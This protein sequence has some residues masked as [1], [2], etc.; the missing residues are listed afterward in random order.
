MREYYIFGAH[1]RGWTLYEYLKLVKPQDKIL[2]FL[3]DNDEDNPKEIEGV[4]VK[5]IPDSGG[6]NADP[7]ATNIFDLNVAAVIYI[8]TRGVFHYKIEMHLRSLGFTDIILVT[9]ELDADLRNRFMKNEFAKRDKHFI[10][11]ERSLPD[12]ERNDD[13]DMIGRVSDI[14]L[15]IAKTAQD[16][17]LE[18]NVS[19]QD[20]EKIIQVGCDLTDIV[21][22]DA[23]EFDNKGDNISFRNSQFCELTAL[24]WIWK[25]SGQKIVGLE[26][27]RRRFLLQNNWVDIMERDRIDVILPVPLC[28]MPSLEENYKGRH[29][30]IVW[31]VTMEIIKEIHPDEH[32]VMERYFR[33]NN[34]YSP[35][36]ML[37]ARKQV[38]DEYCAWMLP[39]IF[40]LNNRIGTLEDKYQNRYPGFVSERLLT[41][42]FD[43]NGEKY[44][45]AYADKSFLR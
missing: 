7:N 45:V 36:N 44:K 26:H 40:E 31:D 25:H 4:L 9:P 24:Y 13:P 37:I 10:K 28:V 1:S 33:N 11:L 35:C 17:D 14:C 38:F 18:K 3:Y 30:P 19:M 12:K 6:S 34:L 23:A 29:V 43:V 41:Y 20:Y 22:S 15:Y 27:W 32:A 5:C 2:G 16:M 42:Y 21:I 39:V 8:A